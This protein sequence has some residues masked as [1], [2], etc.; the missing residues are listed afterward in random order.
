MRGVIWT[1]NAAA[2]GPV[3]ADTDGV[4]RLRLLRVIPDPEP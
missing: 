4:V 3:M 1:C 2:L